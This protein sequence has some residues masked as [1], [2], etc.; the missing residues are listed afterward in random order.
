LLCIDPGPARSALV[1]LCGMTVVERML[2]PNA[3]VEEAVRKLAHA[4]DEIAIEWIESF[5]M[6]VGAEV[7]HTCRWV[8]RYE[9]TWR[10]GSVG[11]LH[12][13]PRRHVKLTLCGSSRAK[14]AN[15][16]AALLDLYGG[17]EAAIGS[18]KAPGPMYG[19][20]RDLTSALAVGIAW[21]RMRGEG[22]VCA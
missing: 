7:F 8:G 18:K 1:G 2:A 5:G 14:D 16:R 20:V 6:P 12:L 4:F 19:I 17:K 13:I 11:A 3:E 9:L 21:Q 22:K 10:R 15:V